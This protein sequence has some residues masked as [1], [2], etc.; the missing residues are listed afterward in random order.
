MEQIRCGDSCAIKHPFSEMLACAFKQI[1]KVNS[2]GAG[3]SRTV[4][5][6]MLNVE[7]KSKKTIIQNFSHICQL[8]KRSPEQVKQFI[9]TEQNAVATI[10][11]AAQGGDRLIQDGALLI[12]GRLTENQLQSLIA[13]Y[14]CTYVK[15]PV[16]GSMDTRLEKNNRILFIICSQCMAQRSVQQVKS[17]FKANTSRKKHRP[18]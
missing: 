1:N 4:T 18:Q 13:S 16:C 10:A 5:L 11:G 8:L 15:C 7:R 14:I 3:A 12:S 17:G 2:E 6:P 9:C